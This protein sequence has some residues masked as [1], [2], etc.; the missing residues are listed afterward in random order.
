MARSCQQ[1][2]YSLGQNPVLFS[3]R[4]EALEG[5]GRGSPGPALDAALRAAVWLQWQRP[6]LE[7]RKFPIPPSTRAGGGGHFGCVGSKGILIHGCVSM[8]TTKLTGC[9]ELPCCSAWGFRSAGRQTPSYTQVQEPQ[10]IGARPACDRYIAGGAQDRPKRQA[11]AL[12]SEGRSSAGAPGRK[13]SAWREQATGPVSPQLIFTA[14][15]LFAGFGQRTERLPQKKVPSKFWQLIWPC[16]THKMGQL[17]WTRDHAT[18]RAELR[19]STGE[20]MV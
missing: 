17:V 9:V 14:C 2:I 7:T 18:F 4:S 19:T 16:A 11:G 10:K 13:P 20:H 6:Q 8:V 1:Y 15:G 12:H 5:A 3:L